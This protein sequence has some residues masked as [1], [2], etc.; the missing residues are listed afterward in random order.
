MS[1]MLEEL[2]ASEQGQGCPPLLLSTDFSVSSELSQR[3]SP[4][5]ITGSTSGHSKVNPKE[6]QPAAGGHSVGERASSVPGVGPPGC[7]HC[8]Q[9]DRRPL[10]PGEH[11]M[12][13]AG[14]W[15]PQTPAHSVVAPTWTTPQPVPGDRL[16]QSVGRSWGG[17]LGHRVAVPGGQDT[18]KQI[19]NQSQGWSKVL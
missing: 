9:G 12:M 19:G 11:C 6:R 14:T 1:L 3:Q 10:R 2:A 16:R 8:Y 4:K 15:E 5:E 18:T 17:S 13:G 7:Q